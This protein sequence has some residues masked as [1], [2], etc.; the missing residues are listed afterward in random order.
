MASGCP[1]AGPKSVVVALGWRLTAAMLDAT[2]VLGILDQLDGAGLMVWLDGGWGVDA[3]LG[4]HSRPHQDLDLA[5][6]RRRW[7]CAPG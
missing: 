4:R 3:L 1:E 5:E 7:L 2:D 6:C